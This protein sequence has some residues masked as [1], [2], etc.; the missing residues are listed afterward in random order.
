M[1]FKEYEKR[2]PTKEELDYVKKADEYYKTHQ[3][4]D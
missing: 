2:T 1:E 4:E 3:P